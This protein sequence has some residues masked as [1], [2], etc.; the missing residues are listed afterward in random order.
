MNI[1][2]IIR[3]QKLQDTT[4]G[5]YLLVPI[6]HGFTIGPVTGLIDPS[7]IVKK[8]VQGGAT[9]IVVHKGLVRHI[10]SELHKTPLLI[11][12]SGSLQFSKKPDLKIQTGTVSEAINLGADGISLHINLGANEEEKMLETLS[13]ISSE[14]NIFGLPL[15]VMMYVRG[16]GLDSSNPELI[17]HAARIAD[18]AGADIVKVNYTGSIETFEEVVHGC[19]IPVVVA[20]GAKKNFSDFLSEVKDAIFAGA[21]GISVGRNIFQDSNPQLRMQELVNTVRMAKK[22][23][24]KEYD[25][26]VDSN[27]VKTFG[28]SIP[29]NIGD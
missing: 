18:E 12:L 20:G 16:A 11:H 17:A 29:N 13:K 26:Q 9:G 22:E 27:N 15:L 21:A 3:L 4:S 7:L 24:I 25:I 6:D 5:A 10:H 19:Q 14:C 8:V 2:K 28:I 23:R 1:G